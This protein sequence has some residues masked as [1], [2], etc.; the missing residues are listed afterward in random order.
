MSSTGEENKMANSGENAPQQVGDSGESKQGR[1]PIDLA[2]V[3]RLRESQQQIETRKPNQAG[4]GK[5]RRPAKGPGGAKGPK[6]NE[7]GDGADPEGD[8]A[9]REVRK[10]RDEKKKDFAPKV[11]AP[12]KRGPTDDDISAFMSDALLDADLE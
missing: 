3:R 4:G 8:N 7:S 1:G 6:S 9:A 10:P 5:D 11:A 2:A 12:L